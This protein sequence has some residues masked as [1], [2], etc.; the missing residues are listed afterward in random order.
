[1][2]ESQLWDEKM[3]VEECGMRKV[4][5]KGKMEGYG[6][7]S[8]GGPQEILGVFRLVGVSGQRHLVSTPEKMNEDRCTFVMSLR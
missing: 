4:K 7:L 3:R 6:L 5:V 1:M 2:N 8:R